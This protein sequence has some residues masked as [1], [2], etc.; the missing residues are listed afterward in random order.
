MLLIS[1]NINRWNV[2]LS[3]AEER[4][5]W[6]LLHVYVGLIAVLFSI[7]VLLD[8]TYDNLEFYG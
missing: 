1:I 3:L 2:S 8:I 5:G 7:L 4:L 6:I